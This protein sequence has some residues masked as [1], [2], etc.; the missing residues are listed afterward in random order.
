[1][2]RKKGQVFSAEFKTRIVLELLEGDATINQIASKHNITVKSIQNWK[3]QFLENAFLA[4]DVAGATKTYKDEIEEL[5]EQN[6][7][8]AKALG[9]ATV[10][11]DFA[12]GK[13]K[14][15]DLSNK[16][17]LIDPKHKELT[18]SEQCEI[19]NISRSSYYYES[20]QYSNQD[21]KIMNKIDEIYTNR[22]FYGY[23]RIHMQLK[24]YGFN[25]G[26]NRVLKYMNV[27]GVDAIFPKK[28]KLTSIKN[29]EH[30]IYPYLLNNIEINRPNQVWSGDITYIRTSKGFVY[31]AAV[32]DWHTKSI[33]SWKISNSMDTFLATDVLKAAI[34]RYGTPEIFNTDQGSQYTSYYHTDILKQNNIK[35]SMNGKGRSIDN[36][37]I[38]RF[39]RTL[40]YENIYITDYQNIKELKEGISDYIHFY[41]FNRFH[42]ALGYNKPMRVYLNEIK[43]VA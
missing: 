6:E 27:L 8:L 40:K 22:S 21:I 14:S 36:I 32:I 7:Q 5:K 10:R 25:I 34:D 28:K 20:V 13:L 16:K 41:N 24:E 33:L 17:A 18:I 1:M 2:G 38:E 37:T 19:L 30:K 26:V 39:F 11:A 12:E 42:S 31:L 35:I 43:N 4:F 23:R 29:H 15:L 3:K 9:K